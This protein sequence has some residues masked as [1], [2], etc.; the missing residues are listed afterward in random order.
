M[1]G[2]YL[3]TCILLIGH[4]SHNMLSLLNKLTLQK[5]LQNYVTNN[6]FWGKNN[7]NNNKTSQIKKYIAE[8]GNWTKELLHP[9]RKR[10]HWTT[11]STESND[12]SQIWNCFD[13]LK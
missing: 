13:V 5:K 12:C 10:F 4:K 11:V 8:A 2:L 7:F 1:L 9:K 6:V 3:Y